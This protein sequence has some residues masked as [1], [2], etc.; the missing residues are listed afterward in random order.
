MSKN[1]KDNN[2]ENRTLKKINEMF[3]LPSEI[4]NNYP[5][6]ISVGNRELTIENYKGII[7]YDENIIRINTDIGMIKISGTG[8]EIKNITVEDVLIGGEITSFEFLR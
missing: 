8:L 3:E 2:K 6:V 5:K 4:V 7:E 1:H